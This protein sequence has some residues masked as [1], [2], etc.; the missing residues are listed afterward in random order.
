MPTDFSA[1]AALASGVSATV[2]ASGLQTP[3]GM[4]VAPSGDILVVERGVSAAEKC[5][6]VVYDDADGSG[7]SPGR[8]QCVA[9][10]PGLNHGLAMHNGYLFASSD[11]SVFRWKWQERRML[12]DRTTVVHSIAYG[13]DGSDLGANGGHKTRTLAFDKG[14]RLY[15]SVGSFGNV[16]DDSHRSRVRVFDGLAEADTVATSFNSGQVW[17][18]G[19]RNEVGLAFDA[20]G[21]LW[22]VENGADNLNRADVGGDVHNDNPGEELNRLASP[23]AY[24]G[25][26]RCWSEFRL[27]SQHARGERTQWAWPSFLPDTTDQWCRDE[28]NVVPPALVMQAHTAPL[29]IT[30]FGAP[31]P[32]LGERAARCADGG[33][34]SVRDVGGA[35]PCSWRGDAFVAQHGSWNREPPVG[36]AL[37]RLPFDAEGAPTGEIEPIVRHAGSDAKWPSGLRPVDVRFDLNGRLLFTSDATGEIVRLTYNDSASSGGHGLQTASLVGIA[38]G[39]ALVVISLAAAAWIMYRRRTAQQRDSTRRAAKGMHPASSSASSGAD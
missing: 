29:G 28:A 4:L 24:Y 32:H 11:T 2:F 16:D 9:S 25:Y 10:A 17:A 30:F 27:P 38:A 19:L 15:I 33:T 22:G 8:L 7:S 26:P 20:H 21:V 1:E 3:R 23:G 39:G 37:V 5:V 35:L 18:D 34:D 13:A 36:Y 12:G 6:T 14:G 31:P